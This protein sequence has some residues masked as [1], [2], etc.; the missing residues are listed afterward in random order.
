MY[1]DVLFCLNIHINHSNHRFYIY[2]LKLQ[3]LC[4]KKLQSKNY[5][6]KWTIIKNLDHYKIIVKEH[7]FILNNFLDNLFSVKL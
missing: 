5:N 3:Q 6:I 1:Y 7:Q 4:F 2:N